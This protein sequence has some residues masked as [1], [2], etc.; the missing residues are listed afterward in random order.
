MCWQCIVCALL[1]LLVESHVIISQVLVKHWTGCSITS[2][3]KNKNTSIIILSVAVN[4]DEAIMMV[5]VGTTR[6]V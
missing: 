6:C 1:L 3:I 5:L 2:T 4:A